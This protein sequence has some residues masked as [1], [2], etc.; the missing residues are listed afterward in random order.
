MVARLPP[1]DTE[2]GEIGGG[3]ELGL[4]GGAHN[5]FEEGSLDMNTHK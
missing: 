1:S 2:G 3:R 5:V 4:T